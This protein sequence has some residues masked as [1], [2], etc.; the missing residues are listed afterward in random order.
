MPGKRKTKSKKTRKRRTTKMPLGGFND[1]QTVRL[2]WVKPVTI[3]ADESD[4]EVVT[5]NANDVY[6]V[7]KDDNH[8]PG[9][10]DEWNARYDN[11]TVLG[12]KISCA[13]TPDSISSVIPG[14]VGLY[15][16]RDKTELATMLGSGIQ[17][18]LEQKNAVK[19]T[20]ISYLQSGSR[21]M[22]KGYSPS[23]IF[24]ISKTAVKTYDK[25][26][27]SHLGVGTPAVYGP[28][29]PVY[30]QLFQAAI[31]DNNPGELSFLV[32]IEFTV[33]FF[34]LRKQSPS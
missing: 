4:Y 22:T 28:A 25:I 21:R 5:F 12:S 26:R 27:G 20:P 11:W 2:R 3:D 14:Y 19:M 32:T 29:S 8:Q 13:L 18:A 15:V 24:G 9:N 17:Y 23:R 31:D 30:F 34:G 33:R 6:E 10:F 1:S 7:Y 16:T